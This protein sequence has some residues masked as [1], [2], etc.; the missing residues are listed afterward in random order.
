MLKTEGS[1]EFPFMN[2]ET[3]ME[4]ASRTSATLSLCVFLFFVFFVRDLVKN[5]VVCPGADA[6]LAV[7]HPHR[8]LVPVSEMRAADAR[9]RRHSEQPGKSSLTGVTWSHQL[10]GLVASPST[11]TLY[12]LYE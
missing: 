2:V 3:E 10:L 6:E 7:L 5:G 1:A 11:L 12:E 9:R 8:L 4:N